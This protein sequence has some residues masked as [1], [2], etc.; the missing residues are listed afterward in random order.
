MAETQYFSHV[1]AIYTVGAA[2]AA[3]T[4]EIQTITAN[5]AAGS[6]TAGT[7]RLSFLGFVT[8][9]ISWSASTSIM[10]TALNNLPSIANGGTATLGVAVTGGTL[11]TT[12][13]TVT[14]SGTNMAKKEQPLIVL[15]STSLTGGGNFVIAEGTPGVNATHRDAPKGALLIQTAAG[16]LF[17][18]TGTSG[19]PTWGTRT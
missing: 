12:A 11:P 1:A 6:V 16:T 7:F 4:D 5:P 13:L 18:N 15:H 19:A 3:G 17:Q 10:E 14:F 8:A 9:P 2:P